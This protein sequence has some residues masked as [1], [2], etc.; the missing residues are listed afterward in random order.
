MQAVTQPP[1]TCCCRPERFR[2]RCMCKPL[3]AVQSQACLA[4]SNL[5]TPFPKIFKTQV[6][7]DSLEIFQYVN[8]YIENKLKENVN[9]FDFLYLEFFSFSIPNGLFPHFLLCSGF[10]SNVLLWGLPDY[11]QINKIAP[12]ALHFLSL[13]LSCLALFFSIACNT[14]CYTSGPWI[15]SFN[16]ISL[17]H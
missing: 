3:P 16:V 8:T 12:P 17:Q 2:Y 1:D 6:S 11:Q 5:F 4:K 14:I 7:H 10:C 9:S 15:I 13:F